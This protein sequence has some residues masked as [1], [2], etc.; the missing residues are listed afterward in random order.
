MVKRIKAQRQ[1]HG[2]QW[3]L[4][5]VSALSLLATA[6]AKADQVTVK[7]GDTVWDLANQYQ[8]SVKAIEDA[9][10]HVKKINSSV[11]LIYAGQQL[12]LSKNSTVSQT[13]A[14]DS[15]SY[16]VKS[17]D[18]LSQISERLHVSLADLVS[19][20]HLS[21]P[22]QLVIGQ[23]L[24]VKG[25]AAASQTPASISAAEASNTAVSVPATTNASSVSQAVVQ[26][27]PVVSAESTASDGADSNSNAASQASQA[28]EPA[29]APSQAATSAVTSAQDLTSSTEQSSAESSAADMASADTVSSFDDQSAATT[30]ASSTSETVPVEQTA[31]SSTTTTAAAISSADA[32]NESASAEQPTQSTVASSVAESTSQQAD[33]STSL[34]TADSSAASTQTATTDYSIAA[35][36][37]STSEQASTNSTAGTADSAVSTSSS[38]DLTT[39]SVVSL[40]VKLANANIP[41]VWGGASLSGMD[42]SGLVDYVF[43]NAEGISLPHYTVSLESCVS[44]HS[45]AEAQPGDI[46]FWG[47]HGSTYHC[48]IYIGNNQY[49]AAPQPGQ[50]VEIETISPYFMPSFAGTVIH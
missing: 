33:S 1:R 28:D 14:V 43:Q 31:A 40:A 9:N 50:N 26:T 41:Y 45:V 8:T 42:C 6:H 39:G 10:P 37:S 46:L 22:D 23:Q 34:A 15:D 19:W 29:A 49:V 38:S 3:L 47:N 12:E 2:R 36:S 5:T 44:Q 20:N 35:A 21:N 18:T 27:A 24:I 25:T 30:A 32:I 48:A 4:G 13:S 17:G 16:T 11:D 7:D